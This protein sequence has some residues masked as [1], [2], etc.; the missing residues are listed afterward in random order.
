MAG[1]DTIF[2]PQKRFI[3]NLVWVL[4]VIGFLMEGKD[5]L[6]FVGIT[7]VQ[8]DYVTY[9]L[10]DKNSEQSYE[11]KLPFYILNM[12]EK[13]IKKWVGIDIG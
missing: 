2:T 8:D 4:E 12:S 10:A 7:G 9:V 1:L 13:E 6:E 3:I 11:L 5:S